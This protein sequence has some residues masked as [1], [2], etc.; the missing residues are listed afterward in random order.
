MGY[1]KYIYENFMIQIC[2][3]NYSFFLTNMMLRFIW[4]YLLFSRPF[5]KNEIEDQSNKQSCNE[6][7]VQHSNRLLSTLIKFPDLFFRRHICHNLLIVIFCVLLDLLSEGNK[8]RKR[9]LLLV[10]SSNCILFHT[11]E[12]LSW[13]YFVNWT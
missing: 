12:C 7:Y 11:I 4:F 9:E 1:T 8:Q 2:F 10:V 5:R 3:S 6:R 13:L